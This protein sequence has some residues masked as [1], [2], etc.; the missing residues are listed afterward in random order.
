T[1]DVTNPVVSIC[2]PN[3]ATFDVEIGEIGGYSDNVTLS[4]TGVPAGATSNFTVNPVS[5]IG[6]S[7]LVISNTGATAPGS[8]VLTITANSTSG[9]KQIDVTLNIS[10]GSPGAISQI[11]PANGAADVAT[12]VDFSWT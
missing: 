10:A 4:L 2:Q 11:S 8:Y 1:L 9:T 3:P 12:P 5:P 6:T 7:Q